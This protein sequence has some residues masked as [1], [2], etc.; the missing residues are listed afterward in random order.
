MSGV[1]E[2]HDPARVS[3]VGG[4]AGGDFPVQNLPIGIFSVPGEQRR[5]GIAIGD[6]VLD[7]AA[8][9]DLLDAEWRDDFSLPVLN[10]WLARGPS[11]HRALR[12]RLSDL[13]TDEH[14]RD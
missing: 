12:R 2:T 13:L 7:L 5:A 4:A 8:A 6:F 10:S 9:A 3:W 11:T 14:F 1:D